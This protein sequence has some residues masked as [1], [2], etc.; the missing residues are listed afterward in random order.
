MITVSRCK[1]GLSEC[2]SVTTPFFHISRHLVIRPPPVR[3]R[4]RSPP[5]ATVL[6]ETDILSSGTEEE[7]RR[8]VSSSA[9][10]S[11]PSRLRVRRRGC[12]V[13]HGLSIERPPADQPR[14]FLFLEYRCNLCKESSLKLKLHVCIWSTAER[15]VL[16]VS[17]GCRGAQVCTHKLTGR[18]RPPPSRVIESRRWI[19]RMQE[20]SGRVLIGPRTSYRAPIRSSEE[21]KTG[22][23]DWCVDSRI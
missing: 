21:N 13:I 12:N 2:I 9:R 8:S 3:R 22:I 10:G 19:P 1:S 15:R 16:W 14:S 5:S 20:S 4:R 17:A 6:G 23:C 18:R 7:S 11:N